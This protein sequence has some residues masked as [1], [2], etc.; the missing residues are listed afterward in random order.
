MEKMKKI[1][2]LLFAGLILLALSPAKADAATTK[3][4]YNGYSEGYGFSVK[5]TDSKGKDIKPGDTFASGTELTV[6]IILDDLYE[7]GP[8]Q[9]AYTDD[10]YYFEGDS[11]TFT[12]TCDF[13]VSAYPRSEYRATIKADSHI[14]SFEFIDAEKK[15]VIDAAEKDYVFEKSLGLS[16]SSIAIKCILEDGYALDEAVIA[17]TDSEAMMIRQSEA[18]IFSVYF[19]S[20]Y[21]GT[22]PTVIKLTSKKETSRKLSGKLTTVKPTIKKN[23]GEYDNEI[24]YVISFGKKKK[25][26]T[27]EYASYDYGN[28]IYS[29]FMNLSVGSDAQKYEVIDLSE[30]G[31]LPED[32]I[33]SLVDR[34]YHLYRMDK[35]PKLKAIYL[36]KNIY[37]PIIDNWYGEY[38]YYPIKVI[39][40]K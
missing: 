29:Y 36:P 30:A 38:I 32:V 28:Y 40:L 2:F 31:K 34:I 17:S 37:I 16:G 22:T 14:K 3:Y 11:F 26:T 20:S 8:T 35:F 13:W 15:T 7:W 9:Y 25:A 1:L 33:T 39:T 10:Y 24:D 27:F 12:P 18:N 6:T 5:I 4:T 19:S 23:K 21:G